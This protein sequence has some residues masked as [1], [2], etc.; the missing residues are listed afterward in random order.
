MIVYIKAEIKGF[1]N[2]AYLVK[3]KLSGTTIQTIPL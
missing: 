3:A 2:E 1:G